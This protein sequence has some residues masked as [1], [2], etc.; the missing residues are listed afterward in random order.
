MIWLGESVSIDGVQFSFGPEIGSADATLIMK[1]LW[2][3]Y[4]LY[5][6]GYKTTGLI[7]QCQ[8][9]KV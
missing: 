3:K 2:E 7:K 5:M 4:M 9:L 6:L 8:K 1:K